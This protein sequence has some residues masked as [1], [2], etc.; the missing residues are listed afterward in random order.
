MPKND[1]TQNTSKQSRDIREAEAEFTRQRKKFATQ[2]D[3]QL[4]QRLR[5]YAKS[6]GRQIQS[7]LEEA[8]EMMLKEKQGYVMRPDVKA[9]QDR[10]LQKY[11]KTFEALAK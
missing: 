4:L 11:A 5:D 3:A 9:A 7:V 10:I 8:V 2:M 6:E 1:Y